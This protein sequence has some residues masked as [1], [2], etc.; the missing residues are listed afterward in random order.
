MNAPLPFGIR[1]C[2]PSCA[3]ETPSRLL[4]CGL[5]RLGILGLLGLLFGSRGG[6]SLLLGFLLLGDGTLGTLVTVRRGPEGEVV[7]QELHDEGAVAVALLGEGVKLGNGVVKGLLGKMAG[8]VG[9]VE[10]LVVENGEVQSETKADRVGRGEVG[11]GNI[12]GVL[13]RGVN[14]CHEGGEV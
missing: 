12:G 3:A 11:L 4:R 2:D 14:C 8:T 6:S 7:A 9:R 5:D 1:L 10:D 13:N